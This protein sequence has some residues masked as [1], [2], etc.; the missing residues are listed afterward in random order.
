MDGRFDVHKWKGPIGLLN[1]RVLKIWPKNMSK[2]DKDFLYYASI[3][4]VKAFEEQVVG[5]TVAHLL[6]SHLK[7]IHLPIP[8]T[9]EEQKHIATVL[10]W[11]DE[12]IEVK[13][14]QNETL[15]KTAIAIF[16]SWFIDFEPFKD[17]EFVYSEELGREIPKGWE[18]NDLAKA[19]EIKMGQSPPSKYYIMKVKA[20]RLFKE[21][22]NMEDIFLIP[23]FTV[24]N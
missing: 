3:I 6:I 20:Y 24:L 18:V 16:K 5:T 17:E 13:K 22:V 19:S 11:F 23:I 21:K 10:S 4:P 12:L 14:K 15:E 9:I 7:Y 2:F 8:P 1:Q